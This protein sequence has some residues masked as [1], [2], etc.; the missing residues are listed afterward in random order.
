MQCQKKAADKN[1]HSPG[2]QQIKGTVH[3]N[4]EEKQFQCQFHFLQ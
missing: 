4:H 1:H 3:Q 2:L